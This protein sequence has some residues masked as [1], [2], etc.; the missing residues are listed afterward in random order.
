M[1]DRARAS[2]WSSGSASG[3]SYR[4]STLREREMERGE[5]VSV[6]GENF[7]QYYI[8]SVHV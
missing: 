2:N 4:T 3:D 7:V 1:T 5:T 8:R 6:R